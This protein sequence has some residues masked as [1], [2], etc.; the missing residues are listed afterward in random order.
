[1]QQAPREIF[2]KSQH[3]AA[4]VARSCGFW[5]D[6]VVP[7]QASRIFLLVRAKRFQSS[8][9]WNPGGTPNWF[10]VWPIALNLKFI[11]WAQQ[12]LN[13]RSADYEAKYIQQNENVWLRRRFP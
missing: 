1:M 12:D 5:H 7:G 9:D 13:L 4:S 8:A 11:W 2:P 10:L 3:A 6:A